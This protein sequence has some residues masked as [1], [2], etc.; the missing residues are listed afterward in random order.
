MPHGSKKAIVNRNT[1]RQQQAKIK[2]VKG[3]GNNVSAK[4]QTCGACRAKGK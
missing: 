4:G 2:C 1:K 3:C